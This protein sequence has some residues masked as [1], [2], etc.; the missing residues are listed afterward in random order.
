[1]RS[2]RSATD[3]LD[4]GRNGFAHRGVHRASAIVEN[5]LTAFAAALELGAGI[6][7][8]VRLTAD[9]RLVVFHDAD[10]WRLCAD[11]RRIG[12]CTLEELSDLRVGGHPI[13]TLEQALEFVGGRVPLLIEVKVERPEFW[14]IGPALLKAIEGYRGPLGTMSF[15]PRVPRWL[16]TNGVQAKRGLVVQ[17]MPAWRRKLA[18]WLADP[19]FLAVDLDILD[20]PWVATWRERMPVY[21]WTPKTREDG[22]KVARFA[23]A[24]IWEAD[25]RG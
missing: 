23:D 7:C 24:P 13:P 1:M 3:P 5:T 19:E 2:S 12:D 18:L 11:E 15:D 25:G 4:P 20:Q 17:H 9:H 8:D 6:E 10:A 16:K 14:R 21:C 22:R